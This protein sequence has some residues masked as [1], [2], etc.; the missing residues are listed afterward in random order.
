MFFSSGYSLICAKA[1]YYLYAGFNKSDKMTKQKETKEK[2]L[3]CEVCG[4]IFYECETAFVF[5]EPQKKGIKGKRT[6]ICD[7][8]EQSVYQKNSRELCLTKYAENLNER[9]L[10]FRRVYLVDDDY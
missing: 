1:V 8:L 7:P 4:K 2:F 9:R 5:E 10:N 6:L 3:K